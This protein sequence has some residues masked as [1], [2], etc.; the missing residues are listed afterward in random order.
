MLLSAKHVVFTGAGGTL[1]RAAVAVA[2]AQGARVTLVEWSGMFAINVTTLRNVVAAVVPGMAARGSGK[3][4]TIGAYSALR[5]QAQMA[6]YCAAKASVMRLTESLSA[7]LEVKGI[8]V[9]GVLP[10]LIDTPKNRADMPNADFSTW[11]KPED[12]A[13]VICFLGSDSARAVHGA[14]V[15]VAGML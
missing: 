11:V 4:V 14:L 12:L 2:R 9:N 10:T 6:A 1:G 7:E 15:P 5:G 8:N 13:N 3:L